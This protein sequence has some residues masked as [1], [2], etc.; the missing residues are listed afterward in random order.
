MT[1]KHYY[2][3]KQI[4]DLKKKECYEKEVLWRDLSES[5]QDSLKRSG[6]TETTSLTL[7][8]CKYRNNKPKAPN[9]HRN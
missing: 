5:L 4:K 9:R 1:W 3:M 2:V 8:I 7:T 6:C